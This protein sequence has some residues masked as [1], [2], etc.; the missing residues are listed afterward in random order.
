MWFV[1]CSGSVVICVLHSAILLYH[2]MYIACAV[3]P[4]L[5]IERGV[6]TLVFFNTTHDRVG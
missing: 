4:A 6:P 1:L 2:H 3:H 5:R